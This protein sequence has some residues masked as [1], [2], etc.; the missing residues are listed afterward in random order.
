[1]LTVNVSRIFRSA[2]RSSFAISPSS[3]LSS[4]VFSAVER[5]VD[6]TPIVPVPSTPRS[7]CGTVE[8]VPTHSAQ[9]VLSRSRSTPRSIS[10][11]THTSGATGKLI[12]KLY[13]SLQ[14]LMQLHITQNWVFHDHG[15]V[16]KLHSLT[17]TRSSGPGIIQEYVMHSSRGQVPNIAPN[18]KLSKPWSAL[19]YSSCVSYNECHR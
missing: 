18:L 3:Y 10:N 7:F 9:L 12:L 14:H 13:L 16:P 5:L 8:T 2:P 11:S 17:H 6:Y 15:I 1:M 4:A 19:A